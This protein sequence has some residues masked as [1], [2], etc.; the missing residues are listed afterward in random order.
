MEVPAQASLS[1]LVS[2]VVRVVCRPMYVFYLPAES[3]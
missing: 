2:F 1:I 3:I